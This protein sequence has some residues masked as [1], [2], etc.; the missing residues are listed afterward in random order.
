VPV[1]GPGVL[2][3]DRA[4]VF[5]GREAESNEAVQML[6]EGRRRW[7]QIEGPS[8]AGK[9]SLARA[10][11]VPMVRKGFLEALAC[12]ADELP[13]HLPTVGTGESEDLLRRAP[14][15][16]IDLWS[17][18]A[19]A[20]AFARES[21]ARAPARLAAE[22]YRYDVFLSSSR[23]DFPSIT[24]LRDRLRDDGVRVALDAEATEDGVPTEVG[25]AESRFLVVALSDDY[26]T[27]VWP[28][29]EPLFEGE[30]AK[31]L[32]RTVPLAL[33]ASM[34]LAPLRGIGILDSSVIGTENPPR[35]GTSA[36]SPGPTAPCANPWA[37]TRPSRIK[38]GNTSHHRRQKSQK[39]ADFSGWCSPSSR[40]RTSRL[41]SKP[42]TCPPLAG[43]SLMAMAS[44]G[45][46]DTLSV[47]S[48]STLDLTL[49]HRF[50]FWRHVHVFNVWNEVYATRIGN[51]F[52][53]SAYGPL[54][55][56]DVRLIV[57][58]AY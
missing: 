18:R 21:P 57:P 50:D 7:L 38:V 31:R 4:P 16:A 28:T 56:A 5:F 11:V 40:S 46:N 32:G 6:R 33:R 37:E 3:E 14:N 44:A 12:V 49:R 45:E 47:P 55:H 23:R 43:K 36:T 22:H 15:E 51:G 48:H 25:I 1:P 19:G 29:I 27:S 26:V 39:G 53:G 17:V 52:V 34:V 54:R 9:S 30:G 58:F 10:G 20:F 41:T 42:S 24:W 35:T 8:G 2:D 13:A